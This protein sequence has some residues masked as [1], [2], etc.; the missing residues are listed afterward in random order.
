MGK[1]P[2]KKAH[3]WILPLPATF[4]ELVQVVVNTKPEP[5]QDE[6][7]KQGSRR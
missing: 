1:K 5:Q 4:D 7:P 2:S 6:P 3:E